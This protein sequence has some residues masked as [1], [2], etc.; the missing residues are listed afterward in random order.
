M[1]RKIKRLAS[2]QGHDFKQYYR[3]E[4]SVEVKVKLLGLL[5]IQDGKSCVETASILKVYKTTVQEW[6]RLFAEEGLVGLRRKPGQGVK[7][8]VDK[9]DLPNIKK[10]IL[11]L[12]TK[13]KGGRTRGRDIQKYLL[14]QWSV[15]YQLSAVYE[16][17]QDLKIVWIS[18]R[19][20][21]PI[22]NQAAQDSFKKN[23]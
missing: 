2:L 3:K 12:Q 21:H 10:G 16:L 15:S 19:S 18:S 14:D 9:N 23:L 22:S 5:H 1:G 8:R 4:K 20:K 17:L 11:E 7:K 13:R 6:I